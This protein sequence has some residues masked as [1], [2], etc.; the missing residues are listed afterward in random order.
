MRRIMIIFMI[1]AGLYGCGEGIHDAVLRGDMKELDLMLAEGVDVNETDGDG[2]TALMYALSLEKDEFTSKLLAAESDPKIRNDYGNTPLHAAV[3][4]NKLDKVKL[5]VEEKN[6]GV[7][8]GNEQGQ[9]PLHY[10]AFLGYLPVV[11]Y[12]LGQGAS[13]EKRDK[14]GYTALHYAAQ[15]GK[16]E[17]LTFLQEKKIDLNA[18]TAQGFSPLH[19]AVV[20]GKVK[21]VEFLLKNECNPE[22]KSTLRGRTALH[23]A[24]M[25]GGW[26]EALMLLE[27]K[28]EVNAL[29]N[30][31]VT[32]LHLAS[33]R[34]H[35]RMVQL[36]IE[37][38]ARLD[39]RDKKGRT[40]FW[41]AND[42]ER[43]KIMDYLKT[44]GLHN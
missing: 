35:L 11:Q 31:G 36:L 5:L 38:G 41:Y 27:N 37:K 29:D 6:T 44:Q 10:A 7:E 30:D 2:N 20:Y 22:L 9:T 43:L 28:A 13:L 19:L 26:D 39:I 4:Y 14:A 40:A 25:T 21:T 1:I 12:L 15:N 23:G 34:G 8:E 32:A 42:G 3:I 24:A 18:V 16:V 17:I 33:F